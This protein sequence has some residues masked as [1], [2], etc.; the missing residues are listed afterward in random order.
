MKYR[1]SSGLKIE[2]D[3]RKWNLSDMDFD[4]GKK[5]KRYCK[6]RLSRKE[7]QSLLYIL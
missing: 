7:T 5:L 2:A 4:N 3:N 6:Y 1:D